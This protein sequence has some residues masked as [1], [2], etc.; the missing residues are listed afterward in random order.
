MT[1]TEG[2]IDSHFA[3]SPAGTHL[4]YIAVSSNGK[5]AL[6]I[7]PLAGGKTVSVD[8]TK[9]TNEPMEIRFSSDSRLLFVSRIAKSSKDWAV[10]TTA[11]IEK[12]QIKGSDDTVSSSFG[13]KPTITA[14]SLRK[15]TSS[16]VHTVDI[17]DVDKMKKPVKTFKI[18]A[19]VRGRM[20]KPELMDIAYFSPDYMKVYVKIIGKYDKK[21]DSKLPDVNGIFDVE[22]SK[23]TRGKSISNNSLWDKDSITFSKYQGLTH[24]LNLTGVPKTSGTSG[25]FKYGLGI[26]N[27]KPVKP[28][29]KLGRYEF[30]TLKAQRTH[31]LKGDLIYSMFIDPQNP[32]VLKQMKSEERFIHFFTLN[33]KSGD[34][35]RIGA[36][37]AKDG[38]I[39]WSLGGKYVAVMR[40]HKN[41]IIGNT[42]LEIY[43]ID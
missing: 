42:S 36:V 26:R 1:F 28:S 34:S 40:L 13:G 3:V 4:A 43:R 24:I 30:S 21:S 17:Y 38:L 25:S 18:S 33:I 16:Q 19:D 20:K 9:F 6:K 8:I 29:Y 2:Y 5:A 14:Y 37:K 31:S 10:F 11:G 22:T 41:W 12:G 32:I 23:L 39:R 15:S 27:W 35:K 7:H